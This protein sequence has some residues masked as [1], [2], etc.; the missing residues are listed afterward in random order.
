MLL[1]LCDGVMLRRFG[2]RVVLSLVALV[3][4]LIGLAF[5]LSAAYQAVA[6][7]LNGLDASLIFAF[8]FVVAALGL[9][10]FGSRQWRRRP[11]PM[12]AAAR[13]GVVREALSLLRTLIRHEPARLVLAGLVLGALAE[14]FNKCEADPDEKT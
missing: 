8:V 3:A 11:R 12:L 1:E 4:L 13:Y 2:V 14:Y 10:A 5:L 6:L 7:M 9:F